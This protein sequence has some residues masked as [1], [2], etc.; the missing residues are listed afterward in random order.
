[1]LQLEKLRILDL[2]HNDLE[3]IGLTRSLTHLELLDLRYNRLRGSLSTIVDTPMPTLQILQLEHNHITGT[4]PPDT[5]FWVKMPNLTFV[6][7]SQNQITGRAFS[8]G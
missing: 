2:A 1:V 4:L 3:N 7:M 8:R 5:E 6:D